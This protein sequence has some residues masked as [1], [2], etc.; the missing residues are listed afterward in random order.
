MKIVV[1]LVVGLIAVPCS[2]WAQSSE[3]ERKDACTGDA[4]KLC[5]ADIPNRQKIEQCL[6]AKRS[7]LT[8][9]CRTVIDG[10][11]PSPKKG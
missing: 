9:A 5:A 1:G 10:G 2:G 8:P 7:Q 3:A 11:R 4:F 6:K